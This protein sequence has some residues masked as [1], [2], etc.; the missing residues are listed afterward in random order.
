MLTEG[1]DLCFSVCLKWFGVLSYSVMP[2]NDCCSVYFRG[3]ARTSL[4]RGR[5]SAAITNGTGM[6][7]CYSVH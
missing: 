6:C 4:S 2:L 7:F 3:K 1:G 5:L